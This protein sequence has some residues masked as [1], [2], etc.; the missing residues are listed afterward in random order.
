MDPTQVGRVT[1]VNNHVVVVVV[2]GIAATVDVFVGS[3]CLPQLCISSAHVFLSVQVTTDP[4]FV[5]ICV[6]QLRLAL[7]I[8]HWM[9]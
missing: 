5:S 3:R 7:V 1:N 8:R 4:V 9:I 2:L 6:F